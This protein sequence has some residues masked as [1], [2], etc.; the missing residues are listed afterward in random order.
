MAFKI[1]EEGKV[2]P[3]GYKNI[4]VHWV[5]DVK[6]DLTRKSRLLAGGYMTNPEGSLIYLLVVS[7][8][9]VRIALTVAELNDLDVIATDIVNEY[10][11]APCRE[12][13]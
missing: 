1:N 7:K 8:D 11:N 6:M 5:F 2:E 4:K 3:V 13:V 9:T 10:L 12:N